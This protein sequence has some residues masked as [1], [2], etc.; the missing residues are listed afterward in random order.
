V[1]VEACPTPE[2]SRRMA[3]TSNRIRPVLPALALCLAGVLSQAVAAADSQNAQ[4]L[5]D[6]MTEASR[7]LNYDGVFVYQR[8]SHMDAMRIIHRA[9]HGNEHERLISLTGHAREVIRNDNS[10]TCIF[11]DDQAV[12]VERSRPYTLLSA[13]LPRPVDKLADS[14]FFQVQGEDRVAGREARI[15]V[16]QPRD[17]FRYGYRLWLDRETGLMLKSELIGE[18]GQPLERFMFTRIEIVDEIPDRALEPSITGADYTWY[19]NADDDGTHASNEHWQVGWSPAG[20]AISNRTN[21]S[22][23]N[24]PRPVH[25]MVLSDGLALVS[26]FVEKIDSER[27]VLIGASKVGAVNAFARKTD[28]HQVMVVGEVPSITVRKMANS[29]SYNP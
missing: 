5:L 13:Q 11:P 6:Q 27:G 20:F 28:G 26:V 1:F 14:Y 25:H 21:E 4:Q 15:V 12:L 2:S 18:R 9:E 23:A 22:L 19:E 7:T 29:V 10:V 3:I 24:S 16:I 17:H 8:D